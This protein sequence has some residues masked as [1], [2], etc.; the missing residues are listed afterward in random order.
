[1]WLSEEEMSCVGMAARQCDVLSDGKH[2]SI[3][4]SMFIIDLFYCW[5]YVVVRV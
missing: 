3:D 1:M 5:L 2:C 4:D